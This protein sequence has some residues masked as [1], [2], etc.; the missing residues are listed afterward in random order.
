MLKKEFGADH[1]CWTSNSRSSYHGLLSFGGNEA[2]FA[3]FTIWDP[4]VSAKITKWLLNT[5][6]ISSAGRWAGTDVTYHIE[7]KTTTGHSSEAFELSN[8][9]WRLVGL[10]SPDLLNLFPDHPVHLGEQVARKH[11][12][13]ADHLARVPDQFECARLPRLSRSR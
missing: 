6:G 7:V 13:C 2:D 12:R 4:E 1:T 10:P 3:D 9:Q 8:N 5:I 11:A